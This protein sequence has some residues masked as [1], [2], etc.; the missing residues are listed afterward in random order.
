MS[1][2]MKDSALSFLRMAA[3]GQVREAYE[4]YV[5]PGFRHHNPWF[6]GD[7]QSLMAGMLENA[8][9]HP[10]KVFEVKMALA[11]GD[12]VAV[13]SH[14]RQ[15]PQARGAAVVHIFRFE[16]GRIVEMWDLGQPVPE[17]SVNDNG[18]F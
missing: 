2:S 11:E 5:G 3:S 16:A 1:Q 18:M 13:L 8:R 12:R 14:V 17:E 7:A 6:R 15:Q 9:Q 4:L 10:D